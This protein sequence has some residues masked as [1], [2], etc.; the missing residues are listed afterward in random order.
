MKGSISEGM[1][2]MRE[3]YQQQRPY[4]KLFS[5]EAIFYYCYLMFYIENKP[6]EVFKLIQ[7]KKLDLVNN[8]L[9]YLPG[10][11]PWH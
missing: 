3:L 7:S 2:V 8:H 10:S 9:V 11:Q 5:N 6:E 1:Q 4:A